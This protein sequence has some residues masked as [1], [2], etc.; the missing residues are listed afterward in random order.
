MCGRAR[1]PAEG[2][3]GDSLLT[4]V[5]SPVCTRF[6][7]RGVRGGWAGPARADRGLPQR[8]PWAPWLCSRHT[9]WLQGLL[10]GGAS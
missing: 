5:A 3:C 2:Q 9:S 6:L 7:Q 8:E 10:T 1:A 4:E